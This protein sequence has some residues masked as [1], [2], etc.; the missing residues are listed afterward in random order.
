VE[1]LGAFTLVECRLE[2]GRTHQVRIHLGERGTPICGERLYDRPL[3]GRPVP[4]ASG[5]ERLCLH[6]AHLGVEHPATGRRMQWQS[7][8]PGELEKLVRSLRG[9]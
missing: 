8:L 4:D 2:T 1:E 6:A 3:H 9:G 7:P 5:T